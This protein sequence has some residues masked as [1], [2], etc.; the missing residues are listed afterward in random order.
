MIFQIHAHKISDRRNGSHSRPASKENHKKGLGNTAADVTKP[1]REVSSLRA[2]HD[3]LSCTI[4][5]ERQ[6]STTGIASVHVENKPK[7][8]ALLPPLL[9]TNGISAVVSANTRANNSNT[10]QDK[11]GDGSNTNKRQKNR[12]RRLTSSNGSSTSGS[13]SS[14]GTRRPGHWSEVG[15]DPALASSLPP[16]EKPTFSEDEHR[17][18]L[19]EI[20][21]K[22]KGDTCFNIHTVYKLRGK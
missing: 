16:P 12:N 2:I 13:A 6:R 8:Q 4:K 11:A 1:R 20:E 15:R 3:T 14:I 7:R 22:V 21:C 19:L 10:S 17:L 5:V 9:E 18:M